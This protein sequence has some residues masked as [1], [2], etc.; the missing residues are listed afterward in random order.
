MFEAIGTLFSSESLYTSAFQLSVLFVFAASGE[1]VA[2]RAGTL[3]IS[4]EGMLLAGAFGSVVGHQWV[5]SSF[6]GLAVGALGGL[7]VAVIHANLS[8]RLTANQFVVGLA[9]N[10]LVLG[11]TAFLDGSFEFGPA[12]AEVVRIPLIADIPLLGEALGNR[13]WPAYLVY[14]LIP[15][16]WWAVFRTRWGLEVRSVGENPQAADVSGIDVN[17]RRRQAI[18]ITGLT[19]GLG[20]AFIVLG[21]VGTFQSGI[22]NGR[23]FIAIAA[24]IFGGWTLRGTVIGCIVFGFV[25]ALTIAI[26][27]N[28]YSI[29]P[30]ILDAAPYIVALTVV[31]AFAARVRAPNALAQPFT[32]GLT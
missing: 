32:R 8:H 21:Q 5:A 6:M 24:V 12:R 16:L 7:S 23:G 18:Y 26:P 30:F 19:C 31:L 9:L 29:D 3:N 17:A 11:L 14:P 20:G 28:R 15:A 2:E 4:V 25:E 13:P 22:I 1:W 27:A 10:V